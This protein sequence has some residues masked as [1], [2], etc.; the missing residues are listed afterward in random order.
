MELLPSK[1]QVSPEQLEVKFAT[2][3]VVGGVAVMKPV[4][5]NLFVVPDGTT[6]VLA[7]ALSAVPPGE[8]GGDAGTG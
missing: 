5:R 1:L 7:L 4:Y 2:G 3:G 6:V 8:S